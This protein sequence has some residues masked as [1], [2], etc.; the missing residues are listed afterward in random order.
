MANVT[1]DRWID[2][3]VH[4]IAIFIDS[5]SGNCTLQT[6]LQRQ[7]IATGNAQTGELTPSNPTTEPAAALWRQYR[8]E[9]VRSGYSTKTPEAP[10]PPPPQPT[11]EIGEPMID[12]V[13]VGTQIPNPNPAPVHAW[14][15][16]ETSLK[17]CTNIKLDGLT[18]GEVRDGK[19]W[20]PD[21]GSERI[22]AARRLIREGVLTSVDKKGELR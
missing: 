11:P 16:I 18:V 7:L 13:P 5:N 15:V 6:D 2:S 3:G 10:P 14:P 21:S 4:G 12:G 22:N 20:V 19:V 8:G 9:P 17:E 1:T